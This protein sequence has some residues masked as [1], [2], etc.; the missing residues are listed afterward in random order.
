MIEVNNLT[1]RYHDFCAVNNIS[2]RVKQN[3]ILGIIGLNGAGKT[4]MI[5][6]I[7]G[8]RMATSGKIRVCGLDPEKDRTKLHKEIGIQLQDTIYQANARVNE[9]CQLFSSFYDTPEPYENL[10]KMM[11]IYDKR[12]S[13]V[14]KLSGGQKQKLS[15]VLA[16]IG[17]PKVLFLDELTTGLDPIARRDMWKLIQVMRNQGITIVL[18]SHFMDEVQTVCDR[19]AI[20]NQGEIAAIG[21]IQ[22][23]VANM[24]LKEKL[25]LTTESNIEY[26]M[27][28]IKEIDHIERTDKQVSIWGSGSNFFPAVMSF[29]EKNHVPYSEID[30][31]KPNLEDAF[32]KIVGQPLN[33]EEKEA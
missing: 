3:E 32:F 33:A 30:I 25:L 20:M 10:L 1:V 19:V 12:K 7:E 9:L 22:E 31:Q 16:L 11:N 18:I 28:H 14:S 13:R 27:S 24:H 5:E 4:S 26:L 17:K 29:L 2:F 6:C 23:V 21:T 15:I 8:L